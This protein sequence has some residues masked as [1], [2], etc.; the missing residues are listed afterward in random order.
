MTTSAAKT[1][2]F[3]DLKRAIEC[4]DADTLVQFYTDDAEM[5]IVDRNRPPSAPMTL[6]GKEEITAFWRDVCSR[7]MT[8]RVGR[9]VIG[10]DRA[11]FVE[12]CAYPDGCHVMSAMTLELRDG[13]I[14]RHLTVQAW[15]EVSCA[16][17]RTS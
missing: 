3:S 5:I 14:A 11:A 9:E 4:S 15:D 12:E 13:R 6:L 10:V 8:H 16:P 1:I 2:D 17:G 7:N